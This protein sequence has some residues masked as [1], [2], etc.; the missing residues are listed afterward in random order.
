LPT[1]GVSEGS[2]PKGNSYRLPTI[3]HGHLNLPVISK[4]EN[5]TAA[6]V[7]DITG[8][9]LTNLQFGENDLRNLPAGVFFI[10]LTPCPEFKTVHKFIKR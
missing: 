2:L 8:R 10:I 7:C 5:G 4:A 3:V 9:Q 1:P 6:K